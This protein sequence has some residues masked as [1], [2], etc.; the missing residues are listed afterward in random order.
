M[1][2]FLIGVTVNDDI[3]FRDIERTLNQ[4][5][6]ET[7]MFDIGEEEEEEEENEKINWNSTKNKSP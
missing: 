2:R 5:N 3:S 6:A 7:T 1:K 4:L